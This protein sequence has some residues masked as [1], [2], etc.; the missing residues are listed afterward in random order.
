MCL[1]LALGMLFSCLPLCASA[2]SRE[3]RYRRLLDEIQAAEEKSDFRAAAQ[4]AKAAG[5]VLNSPQAYLLLLRYLSKMSEGASSGTKRCAQ[6][7]DG[8][9]DFFDACLSCERI[10]SKTTL[11]KAACA[12]CEKLQVY[13]TRNKRLA[14]RARS[15]TDRL[16]DYA[17]G[18]E[19]GSFQRE[20]YTEIS[21]SGESCLTRLNIQSS[22]KGA[23]IKVDG[24][25]VGQT[26]AEFDVF[27]VKSKVV[28]ELEGHQ[29]KVVM[30]GPGRSDKFKAPIVLEALSLP[31]EQSA[32][33]VS[34][35]AASASRVLD[36]TFVSLGSASLLTSG[37]F[38]AHAASKRDEAESINGQSGEQE[39]FE[40]L[41]DQSRDAL[42]TA[43]IAAGVG[44]VA[45]GIGIWMLFDEDTETNRP[46]A[47]LSVSPTGIHFFGTF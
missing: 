38:F 9:D 31:V 4:S 6:V 32:S 7:R 39:R 29:P 3:D 28:L 19:S 27:V 40:S 13:S 47:Q 12:S 36:W 11:Y 46:S 24:Q 23:T 5:V 30:V 25:A 16:K 43:G 15:L 41:K 22:P 20:A 26:P 34:D 1:P 44:A 17:S 18:F 45:L 21:G 37:V 8:I 35:S 10:E 14:V 42:T 33:Q 2:E